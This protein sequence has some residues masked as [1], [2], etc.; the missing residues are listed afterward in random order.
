M[1]VEVFEP[2]K[3]PPIIEGICA[4]VVILSSIGAILYTLIVG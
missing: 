3:S 1:T 4:W 2:R